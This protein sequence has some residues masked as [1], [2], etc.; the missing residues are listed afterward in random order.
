MEIK[1][2]CETCGKKYLRKSSLEKHIIL[3]E[4]LSKTKREKD[5]L[6]EEENDLPSYLQLTYIV[7]ELSLK[8][9]KLEKQMEDMQKWIEKKKK[10]INVISWLNSN[11]EPPQTFTDW[12]NE[13]ILKEEHF[14]FLM[15]N[16]IIQTIHLILEENLTS[17]KI[18]P[19][20]SFSQKINVFYICESNKSRCIW[21]Q[22]IF[23]DFAKLLKNIQ[24]K[25]L[26][27]LSQ[28]RITNKEQIDNN[29]SISIL[30]NKTIIKLMN[31]SFTQDATSGKI[32]SNLYNYLKTDVK[33][34]IE[35]EFEF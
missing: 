10:K 24:N 35:Y 33:N 4:F 21:K 17:N 7:Q 9:S 29:D 30:Y 1:Y 6:K 18:Y 3:C 28:W 12:I 23:E 15:E 14:E 22:M 16:N 27:L 31:I 20:K 34:M 26:I 13:L 2:G 25:L 11:V 5:I 32:K 8:Y 19:I